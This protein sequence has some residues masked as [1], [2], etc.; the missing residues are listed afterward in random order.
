MRGERESS[1]HANCRRRVSLRVPGA[2]DL[3]S[4]LAPS[5]VWDDA[6]VE[7]KC[8][9]AQRTACRALNSVSP[10]TLQADVTSKADRESDSGVAG[11]C[12][13][14]ART[15]VGLKP[16]WGARVLSTQSHQP[17]GLGGDGAQVFSTESGL[18]KVNRTHETIKVTYRSLVHC[19]R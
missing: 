1:S 11:L 12:Y 14:A 17:A 3:C 18:H 7:R 19:P 4:I 9:Q 2:G 15:E 13:P 6:N 16:T 5:C 10:L 8:W